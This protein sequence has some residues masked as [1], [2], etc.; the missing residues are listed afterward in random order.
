MQHQQPRIDDDPL[1]FFLHF[2]YKRIREEE[3]AEHD[4]IYDLVRLPHDAVLYEQHFPKQWLYYEDVRLYRKTGKDVSDTSQIFNSLTDGIAEDDD[5]SCVAYFVCYARDVQGARFAE[6]EGWGG[7]D[8][9]SSQPALSVL[10]AVADADIAAEKQFRVAFF[11]RPLLKLFLQERA[12]RPEK[13]VLLKF[14]PPRTKQNVEVI[15]AHWTPKLSSVVHRINKNNRL[16]P[17][18]GGLYD[19]H[20]AFK[21]LVEQVKQHNAPPFL[22]D[23]VITI[24]SKMVADVEAHHTSI[25]IHD[26]TF[27]FQPLSKAGNVSFLFCSNCTVSLRRGAPVSLEGAEQGKTASELVSAYRRDT[28]FPGTA[29]D[30]ADTALQ[31]L[32][33]ATVAGRYR[34]FKS[35]IIPQFAAAMGGTAAYNDD[36]HVTS[37]EKYLVHKFRKLDRDVRRQDLRQQTRYNVDDP[38]GGGMV[39]GNPRSLAQLAYNLVSKAPSQ[40]DVAPIVSCMYETVLSGCKGACVGALAIFA[41]CVVDLGF[42]LQ[43]TNTTLEDVQ[44]FR[45]RNIRRGTTRARRLQASSITH[46]LGQPKSKYQLTFSSVPSHAPSLQDRARN[47]TTM[48]DQELAQMPKSAGTN[49]RSLATRIRVHATPADVEMLQSRALCRGRRAIAAYRQ[50]MQKTAHKSCEC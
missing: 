19:R 47:I 4:D 23:L 12:R 11:N 6:G 49:G 7:E 28:L 9:F 45:A 44:M 15:C 3:K 26:A 38:R 1:T 29:R 25:R 8:A 46:S 27:F 14:Q 33:A 24:C 5:E 42:G 50:R 34:F 37:R 41:H 39:N 17:R 16:N 2:C 10:A 13:G 18:E 40:M 35:Y 20:M 30:G 22:S 32:R 48:H 43:V 21:P 36:A 31:S